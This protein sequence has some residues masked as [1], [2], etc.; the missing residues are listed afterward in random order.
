MDLTSKNSKIE[1]QP[2]SL[3]MPLTVLVGIFSGLIWL[4]LAFTIIGGI[5]ALILG[6]IF[7][8]GHVIFIAHVRGNGVKLSSQQLPDLYAAV[9]QL[10]Q[11][12]GFVETP[13]VYVIQAGGSLNALATKLFKSD[14]IILFSD[15]ID[16]CGEN[17]AARDMIIA[18]ELGHL[19][20][21]HLKWH[22]FFLPGYLIPFLGTA[23]SRLREY[24]CDRYG[25]AGAGDLNGA[26]RGLAILAAGGK[27]GLEINLE[28]LA[29][30]VKNLNTGWMTLAE[31]FSTHPPLSKRVI[32]LNQALAPQ[33]NYTA[34]GV[35]R[36]IG[37]IATVYI[38]PTFLIIIGFTVFS[39]FMMKLENKIK[40]NAIKTDSKSSLMTQAEQETDKIGKFIESELKAKKPYPKDAADLQKRWAAVYPKTDFP[41]DPFTGQPYLYENMEGVYFIISSPG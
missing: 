15:L 27:K 7:F 30:Q 1:I 33:E 12:M 23:L 21:G 13:E 4:L 2:S 39:V 41:K 32:A 8:L 19:K 17:H 35:G 31:W 18:H 29:H 14:I 20:A 5:Y 34:Q 26:L 28:A 36:A 3:E 11:R 40:P 24:T 10:A 37:I 25:L 9:E 38:L 16:A 6:F 22:W